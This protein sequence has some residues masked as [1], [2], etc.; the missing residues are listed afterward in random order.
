MIPE[1]YIT[2][3]TKIKAVSGPESIGVIFHIE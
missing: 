2:F 3:L 1:G